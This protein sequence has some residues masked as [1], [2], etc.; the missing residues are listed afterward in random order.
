MELRT[1]AFDAAPRC[2]L[3]EVG[4]R[5]GVSQ[6]A[7]LA[8]ERS[9]KSWRSCMAGRRLASGPITGRPQACQGRC[10]WR[11]HIK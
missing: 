9:D 6:S 10:H 4:A 2:S 11:C 8:K 5:G 7:W 1:L 3:D